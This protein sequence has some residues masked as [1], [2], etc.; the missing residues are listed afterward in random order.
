MNLCCI[1]YYL[2]FLLLFLNQVEFRRSEKAI[3]Q[4]LH[5]LLI[6]IFIA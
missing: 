4:K 2:K 5:S 6:L 3:I 1:L